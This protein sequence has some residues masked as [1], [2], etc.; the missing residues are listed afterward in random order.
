MVRPQVAET[1]VLAAAYYATNLEFRV[2]DNLDDLRANMRVAQT[3]KPK[4]ATEECEKM[5]QG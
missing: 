1:N 5:Y 2:W 3:W 4:M